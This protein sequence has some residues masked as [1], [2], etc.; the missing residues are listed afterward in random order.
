MIKLRLF[1]L[2]NAFCQHTVGPLYRNIGKSFLI[3]GVKMQGDLAS[4]DRLVPSLR[5]RRFQ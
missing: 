1:D 4:D 3:S 5:R 2:Y